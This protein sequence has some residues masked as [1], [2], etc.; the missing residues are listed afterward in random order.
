MNEETAVTT[1][2]ATGPLAGV[3]V[4]DLTTTILGPLA[5]QA[6]GD[7][8]AD[9]IKVEPP[10]GD[11]NRQI[12]PSRHPKMAAFFVNVN[13]NKRSIVLD[14][15]RPAA[16]K[17]LMRLV[18]GADVFVHGMRPQAAERLGIDYSAV[19]ACNPGIIYASASGYR[20]DGPRRERPAY[21]DIIQGESGIAGLVGR[22]TGEPRYI[23]TIIAD[24][25]TG[26]TLASAIAMALFSRERTGRGQEIHV[27]MFETM[28]SFLLVEHL[29]SAAFQ[30]QQGSLGYV[31]LLTPYRRPF[32]TKDGF[33]CV[34]ANTDAHWKGLLTVVGCP[35]LFADE[36][37]ATLAQR[38]RHFDEN[39]ALIAERIGRQSTAEL[40]EKLDAADVPNG[41]MNTLEDLMKDPYLEATGFFHRY[42][43]PSAGPMLTTSI[44]VH[45]SDTPGSIRLPP[46]LLGEHTQEL[47]RE[48][49]YSEPEIAAIAG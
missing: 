27:P 11:L 13:R 9:V 36:R 6:L 26:S 39:Y 4:I 5:T 14:L 3:R 2:A 31:R 19:A 23:P 24:K 35:E 15:K 37:F 25:L 49:G 34:M 46:P 48:L 29:W 18:E 30:P 40:R 16:L 38:S 21:D 12:G 47:L 17:A 44:P 10:I 28:V 20:H 8:G 33:I 43:H 42:E 1:K 7:M 32:A 22:Q 45:F 41:A